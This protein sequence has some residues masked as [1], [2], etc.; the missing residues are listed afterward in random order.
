MKV[1]ALPWLPSSLPDHGEE[2]PLSDRLVEAIEHAITTSDLSPGARM[3]THRALAERLGIGVGTVTKAYAIA[4]RRG[5]LLGQVGRGTFVV[6]RSSLGV[7][8]RR[9]GPID[10]AS[11]LP[12]R[13][14]LQKHLRDAVA[15]VAAEAP[16]EDFLDYAPPGGWDRHRALGS[17]WLRDK[18]VPARPDNAL[19]CLGAQ[20]A[21]SLVLNMLC[22]P[23]DIVLTEAVTYFGLKDAARPL[24]LRPRGVPMDAEGLIPEA[25]EEAAARYGARILYTLPTLQNP[26]ARVMGERRRAEIVAVA[27]KMKLAIVEGDV[28]GSLLR[29]APQ[30]L[31]ALAPDIVYYLSSVSKVMAPGLRVGYLVLP[32]ASDVQLAQ[33]HLRGTCL[34]APQAGAAIVSWLVETE[35]AVDIIKSLRGEAAE[36]LALAR[37]ILP[38]GAVPGGHPPS[39]HIWLESEELQAERAYSRALRLGVA[40]TPPDAPSVEPNLMSG[41]RLCLGAPDTTASL[42]RGLEFVRDALHPG[43]PGNTSLV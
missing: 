5:L 15:A 9:E 32:S 34:T 1:N 10:L 26:T 20:H 4:E 38:E 42:E 21:L 13:W 24:R 29:D 30:P 3:P 27:R 11:N 41:L 31:C 35:R 19:V 8:E 6:D 7:T 39:F 40:M 12:P 2:R 23:G 22:S 33:Q 43:L 36:R 28:Y 25:L 37:R 16:P 17:R 14:P 18:G